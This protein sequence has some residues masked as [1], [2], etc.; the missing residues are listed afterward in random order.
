MGRGREGP[1]R[2]RLLHSVG[3]DRFPTARWTMCRRAEDQVVKRYTATE[4]HR[5]VRLDTEGALPMLWKRPILLVSRQ[6]LEPW[7]T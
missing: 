4:T 6:G 2:R 1:A 3:V 7:P 5:G